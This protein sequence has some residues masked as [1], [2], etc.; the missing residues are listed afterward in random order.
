MPRPHTLSGLLALAV[1]AG[2]AQAG[3]PGPTQVPFTASAERVANLCARDADFVTGPADVA[4][5]LEIAPGVIVTI[6]PRE[7]SR[8]NTMAQLN[9]GNLVAR[10]VNRGSEAF[11]QW[12][13]PAGGMS[14]LVFRMR[15]GSRPEARFV[16][17]D[18]NQ[19]VRARASFLL[20]EVDHTRDSAAFWQR[21]V[22]VQPQPPQPLR[23]GPAAFGSPPA[24]PFAPRRVSLRLAAAGAAMVYPGSGGGWVTCMINGCC[25]VIYEL[26]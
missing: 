4:P 7:S 13:L 12:A 3:P 2:C 21:V 15:N 17:A 23:V 14:C 9:A 1:A 18:G 25:E 10:F 5:T 19:D 8:A 6:Q 11:D 20:H 16:S 22:P 26:M 24:A